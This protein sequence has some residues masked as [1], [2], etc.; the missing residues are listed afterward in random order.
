MEKYHDAT[1]ESL[2]GDHSRFVII[3]MYSPL[4]FFVLFYASYLVHYYFL[5]LLKLECK[6]KNKPFRRSLKSVF[7]RGGLGRYGRTVGQP[8]F[9]VGGWDWTS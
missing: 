8:K 2:S 3:S 1:D 4:P 5:F 9:V 6:R 7:R